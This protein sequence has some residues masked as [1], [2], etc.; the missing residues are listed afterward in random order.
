MSIPANKYSHYIVA[1]GASAG[2]LEAIHEFFDSMPETPYTSFIIIQ[3]LS[4]DYKSLLVELVA[5][6]TDMK[7][8]EAADLQEIER[9][10]VYV[11]PN[12]K[13]ITIQKNKLRLAEKKNLK[14][15][16]NAID[17]FLYS[18]ARERKEKAIAV[19]LSGTGTDGTKGAEAIKKEG[20]LVIVQDPATA[21]FDGM[22]NSVIA[23]G[24]ADYVLPPAAIYSEIMHYIAPPP[25]YLYGNDKK[26]DQFLKTVFD[27]IR[28]ESGVEFHYYK[29]PTILRRINK[30]M[31]Q[32]N[33]SSPD[34]Y[35]SYLQENK[36]EIKQLGQDFLI[37]VTRFFRDPEAFELLCEK[38][39]P[40]IIENKEE[41]DT[42]KVWVTA[43]STG[44]EAY[45][46]AMV[47]D[48]V[49]EKT[50]KNLTVKIFASDIDAEAIQFASIGE[51]PASIEKDV[52]ARL[53]R[54]YFTRNGKAYTI[55]PRIRKQIVFTK[56]NIIKDPPF[57]KN[58]LISCRNMLIYISPSMQQR[59]F[60][61]LLF[62]AGKDG[63]IFL[64][65]T[66]NS[67]LLKKDVQEISA[68]WKIYRKTA[69]S[70]PAYYFQQTPESHTTRRVRS[71]KDG[72]IPKDTRGQIALWEDFKQVLMDD[73]SYVVLYI[74]ANFEIREII[75]P[76]EKFLTLPRRQLQ[77]NLLRMVP[78]SISILLSAEIRKAAK[79][80]AKVHL[81]NVRYRKDETMVSLEIFIRA[82]GGMND[83]PAASPAATMIVLRE[84]TAEEIPAGA[85]GHNNGNG[86]SDHPVHEE[87]YVRALE[88]ELNET[89]NQLQ[90]TIEDLETTNEE[91]Q[92]TNEELLSANEELQSSNEELQSLNEELI[93]LNTEHQL[94]IKE[95]IEVNDDL[96]NYFRSTDIAQVFLDSKLRIRKFNPAS[97]RM[98]NFIDTDL[99]RPITHISNNIRSENLL[100][101][102]Q[103]VLNS[104]RA[105][106]K[107]VQLIGGRNLLMRIMPYVTHDGKNDGVIIAFVD[108]TAITDLNNIIR[109]VYNSSS[110]AIFA[111]QAI[112]DIEDKIADFK[113][114]SS[115]YAANA[116]VRRSNDDLKGVSLKRDLRPLTANDLLGR[117]IE[118]VEGKKGYHGVFLSKD[119]GKWYEL[120]VVKMMDGFVATFTNI[121]ERKQ[122][123]E[124]LRANYMELIS[125]RETLKKLNMD[126]EDKVRER[127]YALTLS[128][129]R[130]RLVSRVTNDAI[131][132]WDFVN[133]TVWWSDTFYKQFGYE[134][135]TSGLD[136]NGWLQKI[137]PE[138][139]A[140]TTNSIYTAINTHQSQWT[141][142]YRFRKEN[143][144]YADVLDRA[145]ILHDD[146]GTPYRMLGSMLDIT[147]LKKTQYDLAQAKQALEEKVTERTTQ[148]KQLNEALETSNHDLQQFASI[149]SHDL[150][151]P[152]RKIHM[153]SK[154]IQDRFGDQLPEDMKAYF[155]KITR[156]TD[157]MRA[158]VIDILN[159]SRLSAEKTYFRRTDLTL[160]FAEILEDFEITIREKQAKVIVGDLPEIDLIPGQFRQVL[161]NLLSN[162]LKF[163]RPETPPVIHLEATRIA[164]RSFD[165]PPDPAGAFYR[166]SMK[167]NGIGF[168]EKNAENVFKLFQRLH[169]KD[170]F[171]GTGI[172]LAITKKIIER[173]HGLITAH[174]NKDQG[175]RFDFILPATHE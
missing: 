139:Q 81:R 115:N 82:G 17:V 156:S 103:T 160:M 69:E 151:E 136:R 124:R 65:P 75:G 163:T 145:Y 132:D 5:R 120:T 16:N 4:P 89:K 22:P 94:K 165:S 31:I 142:E 44:E 93:T 21:K 33:F 88:S 135:T 55:V 91:L 43:C 131:W 90:L 34:K 158:L 35:V 152:L 64:G 112:R 39:I 140:A 92:S 173:H 70:K 166:F 54:K 20:G 144:E 3:H 19:I 79:T 15:P 37:G 2:G 72:A 148:L 97:A 128:E 111:F 28:G 68:R 164:E 114:L 13:L 119:D 137:H 24:N 143:G 46:I 73:L 38:V 8:Y 149:A 47:I 14:L 25:A 66:E 50:A 36:D 45:S 78:T 127:T 118:V 76:Y 61:L 60:S 56:H 63:F 113:L 48:E 32:G 109:G 26:D 11:I 85:N 96:N 86:H 83:L 134:R 102:V 53:L 95:L 126:L 49:L 42:I 10:C 150:Q 67:A 12:T 169:P 133:N 6:H 18:L 161:H 52:D 147:E 105:L 98:I 74:D 41:D 168:E 107:E 9:K 7:V 59:I 84:N 110:S 141:H 106:E 104:G 87:E 167:D 77:L 116:M 1:I 138:E 170:R 154:A 27:L 80:G 171:E 130:F 117:Y 123:E 159:F 99:G 157:R 57:I 146:N 71:G 62:A 162:A 174:A 175:A 101:E 129:E 172:G 108:I 29:T 40:A 125:A 122:A 23:A 30:R 155:A 51:Y 58:D 100:N 153:F 121:T